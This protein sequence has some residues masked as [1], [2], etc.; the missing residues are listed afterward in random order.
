MPYIATSYLGWKIFGLPFVPFDLFDWLVRALPGPIVTM[1]IDVAVSVSGS[2]H[3]KNTARA[4]KSADQVMAVAAVFGG[5]VMAGAVLGG[6]LRVADESAGLV[7]GLLGALL[8]GLAFLLEQDLH[9]L[10]PGSIGGGTWVVSTCVAWGLGVRRCVR[11][12]ARG[13][14]R[15]SGIRVNV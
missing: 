12:R 5:G 9:R 2:L 4:A 13:Q 3:L 11:S 1:A 7:G 10:P 15:P 14:D 6:V 8:G